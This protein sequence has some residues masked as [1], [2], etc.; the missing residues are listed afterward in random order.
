MN[1]RD[2]VSPSE[3]AQFA[4]RADAWWDPEGDFAPLH[5]LNPPRLTFIRDHVCAQFDRDG[6]LNQPFQDLRTVDIGCGG[7]L[8]TEPMTRLG[9]IVTGIDAA[10]ENIATAQSHAENM[11][12]KIEYRCATPEDLATDFGAFDIVLNMEVVEHVPDPGAFIAASGRLVRPGGLMFLATLNRTVKSLALGKIAA[13]YVLR[14]LPPGTHDW[15]KF[16]RPAELTR[17]LRQSGFE[18][19]DL[20][21]VVYNPMRDDWDLSDDLDV[22]YL[23]MARKP[24]A[25]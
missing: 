20:R 6:M 3:V 24:A 7:G 12:L 14:W 13:E 9:A 19:C 16:V 21:G 11:G 10:A 8:L 25:P 23:A 22:N 2:T 4:A 15:R 18:L 5:R 1:R 17:W